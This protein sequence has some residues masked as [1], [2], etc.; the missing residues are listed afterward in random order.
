MLILEVTYAHSG[1]VRFLKYI[2]ERSLS[3]LQ[4]QGCARVFDKKFCQN[5]IVN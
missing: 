5:G 4:G 3:C 2:F 1:S